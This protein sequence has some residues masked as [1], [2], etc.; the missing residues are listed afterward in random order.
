MPGGNPYMMFISQ[1]KLKGYQGKM[2]IG[3]RQLAEDEHDKYS[4]QNK[5]RTPEP[6]TG[7]IE[8][9]YRLRVIQLGCYYLAEDDMWKT[10]GLTVSNIC[11]LL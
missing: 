7:R 1:E 8:D 3:I 10:D 11:I 5:P 6:N 9:P 4:M 2:I